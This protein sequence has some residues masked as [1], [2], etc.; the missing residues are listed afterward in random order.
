MRNT[1]VPDRLADVREAIRELQA[2]EAELRGKVVE[3]GSLV[4]DRFEA[5]VTVG[6][7]TRLDRAMLA[8]KVGAKVIAE[9]TVPRP[10]VFVRVK[11]RSDP[12]G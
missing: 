8:R 1:P 3:A 10:V 4:G 9:C 11:A 5:K 6:T 2:E 12:F 7:Q